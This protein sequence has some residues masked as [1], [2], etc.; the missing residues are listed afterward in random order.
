MVRSV[1]FISA[2]F[3]V[4]SLVSAAPAAK[5]VQVEAGHIG[6]GD[7]M[8]N[9]VLNHLLSLNRLTAEDIAQNIGK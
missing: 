5:L 7:I 4:A 3:I 2:F 6:T 9:N 1:I 8:V